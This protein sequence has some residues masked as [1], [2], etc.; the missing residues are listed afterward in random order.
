MAVAMPFKAEAQQSRPQNLIT[1]DREPYHFGFILGFNMIS[2]TGSCIENYKDQ[3]FNDPDPGATKPV[4]VKDIAFPVSPGFTVGIV[5]DLRLANY[6]NLRFVPSLI[7][8]DR[9]HITYHLPPKNGQ[10][11][12]RIETQ[13]V[14]DL[15]I[16]LPLHVKYRSKRLNN[17]AAY[18][19]GGLN[20][21][22]DVSKRTNYNANN[23][24]NSNNYQVQLKRSDIAAELGAGF[25]FYTGYFKFGIEVKMSYG[26]FNIN[27]KDGFVYTEVFDN[28]RNKV[29][30]LSF[31][32]E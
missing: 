14:S 24:G 23:E 15:F 3:Y 9:R 17:V 30:Q 2:L 28:L 16:D 20:Y 8:G 7:F 26:L 12:N 6:F 31:T 4:M 27:N 21:R 5:G 18:L 25:D 32:F 11:E 22:I 10:Q 1:Y 19:L 13:E 29:F